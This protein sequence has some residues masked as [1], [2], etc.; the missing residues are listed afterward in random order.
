M[1]LR[2]WVWFITGLLS[3]AVIVWYMVFPVPAAAPVLLGPEMSSETERVIDAEFGLAFSYAVGS[4]GY[5]VVTSERIAE[6]EVTSFQRAYRL[7]LSSGLPSVAGE[8]QPIISISIYDEPTTLDP[9][10]WGSG[11]LEIL[12]FEQRLT[13][14]EIITVGEHEVLFFVGDGLY[15]N[16][17]YV[18]RAN[19]LLY[20]VRAEWMT[21]DAVQ[22]RDA[23]A[24]IESM[25]FSIPSV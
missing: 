21:D 4:E 14:P 5:E 20:V 8:S 16:D 10:E 23:R 13:D 15:A 3:A 25:T 11:M 7:Y 17:V 1:S 9:A 18:L 22:R 19:E 24:V 2:Q 12:R 6:G